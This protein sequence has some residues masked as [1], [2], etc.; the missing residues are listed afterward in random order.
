MIIINNHSTHKDYTWDIYE[1]SV[2]MSTYLVAFVVSDFE[3]I[4]NIH[5]NFSVWARPNAIEDA[6]IALDFG[7]KTLNF[8]E[9]YTAIEY[10][11]PKVDLIALPDFAAVS[12]I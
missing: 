5:K 7:E 3:A 11:L 12:F 1:E 4:H 9:N 6:K 10:P 2:P 8:L